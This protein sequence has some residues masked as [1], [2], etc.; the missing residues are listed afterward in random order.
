MAKRG[1]GEG[2]IYQ[3][4]DGRWVGSISLPGAKRKDFYG[5]TRRAVAKKLAAALRDTQQGLPV[6]ND[7]ITVQQFLERWLDEVAKPKVG[8]RTYES[9]RQQL[10]LHVL[11]ELGKKRLTQ[12]SPADLQRYMNQ[13]LAGGLSPRTV[14]YHR[15]ILRRALS[16]ALRWGLV[17]RNIATLVDPPRVPRKQIEPLSPEETEQF[18]R[19]VRGQRLEALYTVALALGLRQGEALGLRWADV[20]LERAVIRVQ[21]QVQRIAGTLQLTELKTDKSRRTVSLPA[22]AVDA[23]REQKI[24]QLEERLLAGARWQDHGLVFPSTIGTPMDARNLVKQYHALL[25]RAGLPRKRFHDLRHTCATLLLIQGE[26]LNVVKEVL[27]HS[28]ISITADLYQYVVE[29]LKRRAADKMQA[30]LGAAR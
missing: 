2:S 30:L 24:R 18:L 21:V 23:L 9:Y 14:Q 28:Q 10:R 13:K 4:K 5:Q 26:D 6:T 3:R 25:E 29:A 19:A 7:R 15:A 20:D 22:F 17:A 16:Q 11:P 8:P 1:H 12:L 27:G